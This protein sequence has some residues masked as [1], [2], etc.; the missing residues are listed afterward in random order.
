MLNSKILLISSIE[1]TYPY[2]II[3]ETDIDGNLYEVGNSDPVY[4]PAN[5][6]TKFLVQIGPT[7]RI[8]MNS[9]GAWTNLQTTGGVKILSQNGSELQIQF[10]APGKIHAT[11]VM[12]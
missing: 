8:K 11:F 9:F 2:L 4:I 5:S 6:T 10:F 1:D 7:Y 12:N 3:I